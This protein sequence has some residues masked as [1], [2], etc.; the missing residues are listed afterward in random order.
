MDAKPAVTEMLARLDEQIAHN[1]ER[2]A[3]H[4]NHEAFHRDQRS[5]YAADGAQGAA[6][7]LRPQDPRR[8]GEPDLRRPPPPP[9]RRAPGWLAQSGRIVRHQ[10][11]KPFHE[12]QYSRGR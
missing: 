10:K 2:A 12:S 8:R 6:R 4:A 11:G 5:S 1:A 9:L 7:A 3:F